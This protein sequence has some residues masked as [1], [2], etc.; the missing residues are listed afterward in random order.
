MTRLLTVVVACVLAGAVLAPAGAAAG[1]YTVSACV[2]AGGGGVNNSWTPFALD[3]G[4]TANLDGHSAGSCAYGVG[5][6]SDLYPPIGFLAQNGWTLTAPPGS[7][8]SA[9]RLSYWVGWSGSGLASQLDDGASGTVLAA[10][11]FA[12]Q[13]VCGWDP[14][15]TGTWGWASLSGSGSWPQLR[16]VTYC[17]ANPCSGAYEH[18]Y[19]QALAV[20]VS[21]PTPPAVRLTGGGLVT[22]G[23]LSGAQQVSFDATDVSGIRRTRLLVDGRLLSDDLRSCDYSYV[24]PCQNRSGT[25]SVDTT[26]LSDG[27]HTV[28]VE[29]RDATDGNS[30]SASATFDVSNHPPPAPAVAV[31]GAGAWQDAGSWTLRWTNP[32]GD[33][34]PVTA[35][36]Y[37][38]CS[39]GGGNCHTGSTS[40]ADGAAGAPDSTSGGFDIDTAGAYTIKLWLVDAAG[41]QSQANMSNPVPLRWDSA[42][43]GTAAIAPP[44]G[45]NAWLNAAQATTFAP[46]V[47]MAAGE[48]V[49]PSGIAGYAVSYGGS[50]PGT[51]VS[52]A[53]DGTSAPVSPPPGGWPEG[54]DT[55]AA[56]AISATGVPATT[57]ATLQI[58]VDRTPPTL[59]AGGYGAPAPAWQPGPVT[60]RL[61]AS[62]ALSGVGA[63]EEGQPVS[64]GAHIA[65]A[66]DTG[67][68]Q[69]TPGGSASVAV[70]GQGQHWLTFRAYDAA[71]NVSLPRTVYVN[72]GVP[73]VATVAAAGFWAQTANRSTFTAADGFGAPCPLDATLTASSDA[74]VDEAAATATHAGAA[75]LVVRSA[76]GANARTLVDFGL[77]PSGGC[78]VASAQLRLYASASTAGRT[79]EVLRA[80]AP[81]SPAAVTWA[82]R[83]GVTGAAA[84]FASVAGGWQSV[85]VT[86]LIADAYRYGDTGLVVRDATE[87]SGTAAGES[88]AGLDA[89]TGTRPQLSI[90]FR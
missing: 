39:L 69:D 23:W 11:C 60:V 48:P 87:S 19:W 3:G 70:A 68:E 79:L 41:N 80:G 67:A 2:G 6:G 40:V 31:D 46:T 21:D 85:D 74:Y 73:S 50:P 1:T 83:P 32:I 30:S 76:E 47:E 57:Y 65:Y 7:S 10:P 12:G 82:T 4:S 88:L 53:A 75:T 17:I 62:D 64:S 63:A 51:T 90:S 72:V 58:R 78:S 8:L 61:V 81:W 43:P 77:P 26:Q 86:P 49:P 52:T 89:A 35:A 27:P 9:Y 33:P 71:G 28:A 5:I 84:T 44:T 24:V 38:V 13:P 25:Y 14:G 15:G 45:T 54:I 56:R 16:L 42:T 18:A 34:A 36:G 22:G 37:Q 20:A 66:L 59:A 55:I 29:A